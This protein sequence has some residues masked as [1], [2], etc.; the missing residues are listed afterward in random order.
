MTIETVGVR[1][2]K[3]R[4]TQIVRTIREDQAEYV[5]T[6]HGEPVAVL[7]PFTAEDETRLR[8]DRLEMHLAELEA[9]ADEIGRA[10][11]SPRSGV[12]LLEAQRRG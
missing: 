4:V 9:L 1:D 12:E 10:W 11:A 8:V 3:N 2:L 7:R 5:V 6:V